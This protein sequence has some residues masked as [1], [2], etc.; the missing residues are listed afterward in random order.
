MPFADDAIA[1][2]GR[3]E[4]MQG[5]LRQFGDRRH[6]QTFE[7]ASEAR[8]ARG[9]IVGEKLL[10]EQAALQGFKAGEQTGFA[11]LH[12]IGLYS[13]DALTDRTFSSHKED[14]HHVRWRHWNFVL[15][16]HQS[17]R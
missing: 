9:S 8:L 16:G 4:N 6:A 5:G 17:Q 1:A 13:F 12:G 10:A 7:P 3:P 14:R 2:S 11:Y 15:R